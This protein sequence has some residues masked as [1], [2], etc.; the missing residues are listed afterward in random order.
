MTGFSSFL[1]ESPE[2]A[3]FIW[4]AGSVKHIVLSPFHPLQ[5]TASPKT[6]PIAYTVV[7]KETSTVNKSCTISIAATTFTTNKLIVHVD[8]YSIS[9]RLAIKLTLH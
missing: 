2:C 9:S 3:G 8:S 1:R 4:L 5:T 7:V 6:Q